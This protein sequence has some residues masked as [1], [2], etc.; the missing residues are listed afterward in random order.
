[1]LLD[2]LLLWSVALADKLV[3]ID[4]CSGPWGDHNVKSKQDL[5]LINPNGSD[6]EDETSDKNGIQ[7]DLILIKMGINGI[8]MVTWGPNGMTNMRITNCCK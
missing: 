5:H 1:M 8:C 2:S 4:V 7:L 3:P 6:L